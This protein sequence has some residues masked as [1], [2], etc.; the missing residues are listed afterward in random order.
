MRLSYVDGQVTLAQGGQVLAQ[1]AVANAP[2]L[3][4]MQLTTADSGKA[5][6]QFEDGSVARL[7]P[8]SSL[9]LQVLQGA[10]TTANAV[11]VLNSGLA[12]FEFQGGGQAGQMSVQ[13]G[14]SQV[15]T[16]GFTVLRVS[17][18]NP[19][20]EVAVFSGNAHLESAGGN[21]ATDLH[22][23]ESIT[24]NGA[25]PAN[26]QLAESIEPD[27]WDAWNSD[28]D[29][30]MTA[31]AASQPAPQPIWAKAR[32]RR[33]TIWT[34]MA[35]GTTCPGRDISGRLMRLRARPLTPTATETG[36]GRRAM[37]TFGCRVIRGA[38]CRSSVERGTS[39]TVSDGDGRRG[40]A[41][42]R[43]GGDWVSTAARGSALGRPATG[44]FRG[45][46]C[47]IAL[48]AAGQFR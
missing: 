1:Q 29:Q 39:S 41:A 45:R 21:V 24:L 26:Y 33:G 10:G 34:P 12:Y 18:D 28:R 8:D 48:S 20:G 40:S 32:I 38:I 13:F 2:L 35:I 36:C 6:I 17:M 30:A 11:L 44:R 37:A 42:V 19:P 14:D 7:S 5:E 16:S 27:S 46:S 3:E 23:G 4:G 47:R 31:E 15:T 43:R 22:G 25:N 9:T